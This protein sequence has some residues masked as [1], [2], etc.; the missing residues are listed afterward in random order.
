VNLAARAPGGAPPADFVPYVYGATLGR[1]SKGRPERVLAHLK[2]MT[3]VQEEDEVGI[4]P[5]PGSSPRNGRPSGGGY[6]YGGKD[7]D[8]LTAGLSAARL[9]FEAKMAVP[10]AAS[11]PDPARRAVTRL[12]ASSPEPAPVAEP[13]PEAEDEPALVPAAVESA[14]RPRKP[15]Q[16]SALT[17]A[18]PGC[19][20]PKPDRYVTCAGEGPCLVSRREPEPEPLPEP[21]P[22]PEPEP[23]KRHRK[24][25]Y[26]FGS[27]GHKTV[28]GDA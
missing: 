4:K 26:P 21:V 2:T 22:V 6:E 10:G 8:T 19:G 9:R 7:E 27:V 24:C 14:P 15:W 13:I 17:T 28:C 11:Y 5:A 12:P 16:R 23:A 25:G 3:A 1:P 20:R 18:C